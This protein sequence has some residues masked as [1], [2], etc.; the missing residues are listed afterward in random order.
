MNKALP[1]AALSSLLLLAACAKETTLSTGEKARDHFNLWAATTYPN[2]QLEESGILILEDTPGTGEPWSAS[3]PYA[4]ANFTI[5]TL[6]GTVTSTT[7]MAVSQQCGT[8]AEGNYYGPRFMQLG[9]NVSYAG[10]DAMLQGMRKGGRR[11]AAIPSWLLTT[12]RSASQ[13]EYISTCSNSTHLI[14]DIALEDMFADIT[15]VEK[16]SLR[17]YVTRVYGAIEPSSYTENAPDGSFYFIS[18]TDPFDGVEERS[19]TA[20]IK[21]NYTARLLNGQVFDTTHSYTAKEAGIY[22]KNRTYSPVTI[23]FAESYSDIMLDG[24]SSLIDGFKGGLSLMK[25]PGQTATILFVSSLGYS[26]SGSGSSIPPY[27]PLIFELELAE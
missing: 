3:Y 27:S 21:L 23:T 16:D 20:T 17:S 12:S 14:Y 22:N 7:D 11:V 6:K 1:L 19:S 9:E 8:Y 24:S 15:T 2:L 4:Y 5:R 10:V 26:A 18:N 25:W 13:S